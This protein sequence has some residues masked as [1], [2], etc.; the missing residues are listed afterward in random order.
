MEDVALA[1]SE[2][3][4]AC[5]AVFDGHAGIHVAQ[6]ASELLSKQSLA[7][8]AGEILKAINLQIAPYLKSM[9]DPGRHEPANLERTELL[10][11]VTACIRRKADC[12]RSGS[13]ATLAV[14]SQQSIE[15]A[16]LG[17]SDAVLCQGRSPSGGL[18]V[19]PLTRAHTPNREDERARI[20]RLGGSVFQS[21]RRLPSG[22]RCSYGPWRCVDSRGIGGHSI[23]RSLGNFRCAAISHE[24]EVATR[25]RSPDDLF[26]LVATDGV[27]DVLSVEEACQ[28]VWGGLTIWA[29]QSAEEA[30][31]RVV[32]TAHARGSRDNAAAAVLF[33][34]SRGRCQAVT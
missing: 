17:D 34:D 16:W 28:M 18:R 10:Q 30:C 29:S 2:G 24:V 21:K 19:V 9:W 6:A 26:V 7:A 13:T 5:A 27:W 12:D 22:D 33:L 31:A 8:G 11:R 15:V 25:E 32:A 14:A 23:S 20:E 1:Y 3:S 4:L